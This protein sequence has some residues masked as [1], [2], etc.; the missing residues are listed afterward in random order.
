VRRL[1]RACVLCVTLVVLGLGRPLAAPRPN[2]S[3]DAEEGARIRAHVELLADDLLEGREA[4]TRG[5]DIAAHYVATQLELSGF[6]PAGDKG[7]Y[8]QD[9]P[10][11]E[12]TVTG[13]TMLL[14][15]PSG[16]ETRL[17]IPAEGM[18]IAD[19]VHASSDVSAPLVFVGF[20]VTAPELHYDDYAGVDVKGKIAVMFANAPSTF[21]SEPRAHFASWELKF[22]NAAD[23]GAIAVLGA[24]RAEDLARFSWDRVARMLGEPRMTWVDAE[25]RPG[26]GDLRLQA[27]GALSPAGFDKVFAGAAVT[28][29]AV[30]ADATAGHPKAIELPMRARLSVTTSHRR[31]SSRNVVA[32]LRG[33]DPALAA[34]SVALTAHLDHIGLSA[35]VNGDRIN[36]GAYDN[37]TGSAIL[38]EV[39][40]R[41]QAGSRPKRSILIAFVTAEEKGLLGSD[42]FARHPTVPATSIVADVNL[43]MPLLMFP[44]SSVIAW[45]ADNSTLGAVVEK[46]ARRLGLQVSPDPIPE[47]NIFVRSDQYSFVKQGVPAIYLAPGFTSADPKIDGQQVVQT[48]LNT[49]YHQPSDDLSL[50]IDLQSAG[51][52][53]RLNQDVIEAIANNPAPPAWLPGNFFGTTFARRGTN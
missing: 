29:D 10:L 39:A 42:Y 12:S 13:S 41:L 37:A 17:D 23:H 38:L 2:R 22:R 49:H 15:P 21:P 27:V 30:N 43:D 18:L 53:L 11:V 31:T 51:R 26:T 6:E 52:F 45:G 4:G 34:T 5:F 47:E 16:G 35:P 20:G 14:T 46:T 8:F 19:H 28:V 25:G 1:H 7:T 40:R 33:A 50:P 32:R 3:A 48:F 24:R 9:V 36:N 44:M